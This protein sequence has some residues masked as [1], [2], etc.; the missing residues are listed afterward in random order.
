MKTLNI[1]IVTHDVLT[2]SLKSLYCIEELKKNFN[3]YFI[4]LRAFFHGTEKVNYD[5]ELTNE[6]VDFDNISKFTPD[7]VSSK[8]FFIAAAVFT[9]SVDFST[10]ILSVLDRF[11]WP[12]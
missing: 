11:L 9:G 5:D 2:P 7:P 6:F 1:L 10:T 12:I 8:I 4:S 3:V